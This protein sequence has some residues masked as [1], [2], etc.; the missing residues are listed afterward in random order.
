MLKNWFRLSV[1]YFIEIMIINIGATLCRVMQLILQVI[2]Q[3][4]IEL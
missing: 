3:L 4:A 2:R 1:S